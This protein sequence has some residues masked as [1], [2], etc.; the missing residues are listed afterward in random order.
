[1][2][3]LFHFKARRGL[4]VLDNKLWFGEGRRREGVELVGYIPVH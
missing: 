3:K 1:L 4:G 2:G